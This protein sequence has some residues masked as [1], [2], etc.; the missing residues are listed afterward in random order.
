LIETPATAATPLAP[1]RAESRRAVVNALS[2]DRYKLQ[3]TISGDTL[4]KLQ[5][6]KDRLR[7]AIP[8][9][10]VSQ[11]LDRA[12]TL[13]LAETAK[14]KFAETDRPRSSNGVAPGSH[15]VS[16]AVRRVVSRRDLGRCGFVSK[17]GHRCNERAFV[18]FHHVRPHAHDGPPTVMNIELRCRRH[19]LYEWEMEHTDVRRQ[20]EE[21]LRRRVAAEVVISKAAR[22]R[23]ETSRAS[24]VT[25][26]ATSSAAPPGTSSKTGATARWSP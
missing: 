7:H 22:T 13:L 26:P 16:A 24:S 17:D 21:W 20:E 23:S 6:A 1:G 3:L 18:E 12:L 4:E 8:S 10:D 19:N 11:I 5:L 25:R 15:D 9:G 2:P 14:K